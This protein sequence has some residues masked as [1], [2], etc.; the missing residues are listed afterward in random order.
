M[1]RRSG[2]AV[3]FQAASGEAEAMRRLADA[4]LSLERLESFASVAEALPGIALGVVRADGALLVRVEG[5]TVARLASRGVRL[6]VGAP[7]WLEGVLGAAWSGQA[8]I[9]STGAPRAS[10]PLRGAAGSGDGAHSAARIGRDVPGRALIV[11][12]TG[13]AEAW[14]LVV[15]RVGPGEVFLPADLAPLTVARALAE[16]CLTRIRASSAVG[17]LV[18]RESA[19]L[20]ASSEAL[21]AVDATGVV[22]AMSPV[23]ADRLGVGRDRV[24][25]RRLAEVAALSSLAPVA[26]APAGAGAPAGVV[27]VLQG[28][29][30]LVRVVAHEGGLVLALTAPHAAALDALGAPSASR[31]VEEGPGDPRVPT[32]GEMERVTIRQALR[33]HGGSVARAA[34]ALGV[35]KGTVYNKMRRYGIDLPTG[36]PLRGSVDDPAASDG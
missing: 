14:V 16:S 30:M 22:R 17:E 35:A 26:A 11:P 12:I 28:T 7:A 31:A 10:A 4:G 18:A 27:V 2:G 21:L 13:A 25:G 1:L 34:K 24:L 6:E 29:P 5:S 3:D 32:W 36:A 8:R 23:A 33:Q 19:M 15:G 9:L 20:E